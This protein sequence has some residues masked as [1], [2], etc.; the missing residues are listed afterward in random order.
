[1]TAAQPRVDSERNAL[2]PSV[3]PGW[4]LAAAGLLLASAGLQLVASLQRWATFRDS[5]TR[6]DRLVEDHLFDYS[7]PED[8]WEHLG[9]TAQF[10]GAGYL[11]L[12]LSLLAILQALPSRPGATARVLTIV[13]VTSFGLVGAHA[14]ISGILGVPTPL[15]NALPLL[16]LLCL[17]G[18]A[19]LLVVA[20]TQ[21]HASGAILVTCLF[22]VGTTVVGYL[23][24]AFIIAPMI[25]GYQSYDSTPWTETVVAAS[26]AAAGLSMLVGAGVAAIVRRRDR[27]LGT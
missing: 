16:W 8:P 2:P 20:A 11:L 14:L 23:A 7:Y 22:L 1:M 18:L 19:G 27:A 5:W 24:A 12:A 9:T 21:L 10:F 26:T 25:A 3:S 13:G 4:S 15:Q 6:N 17:V